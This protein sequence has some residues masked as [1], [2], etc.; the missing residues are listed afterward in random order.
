[1]IKTSDHSFTLE[2]SDS[3]MQ[4]GGAIGCKRLFLDFE[5]TSGERF[6]KGLY[7]YRGHRAAGFAVTWDNHPE[8]YYVPMRH[9]VK[10]SNLSLEHAQAYLKDALT[11]CQVWSNA[12]VKFDAH[13]ALHEGAEFAC[14]LLDTQTGA[15]LIDSDRMLRGGYGLDVLSRDF[16]GRVI[17]DKEDSIQKYLALWNRGNKKAEDYGLVPAD[18]M[19]DYACE[20]VLA[21][22][23]V[24]AYIAKNMPE[25]SRDIWETEQL[26]TPV[27][28]DIERRGMRINPEK[29]EI[30]QLQLMT[31]L[32]YIEEQIH[33]ET[34]L[35]IEPHNS[36]DCY[37]LLC[38]HYGLPVLEFTDK[39]NPS[40]DY[41][42]ML[43][44]GVHPGVVVHPN[45]LRVIKLM[46]RYRDRYTLLHTFVMPYLELHVD[47]ILHPNYNQV[48]RT[49]R[50]SCKEPNAQQLSHEGR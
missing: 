14:R 6:T 45:R 9:F 24:D 13:V 48:V 16:C 7:P 20:D 44:Y 21:N 47:G 3:L 11:K 40:F 27:L 22:R 33:T 34:G 25:M 30:L 1:M 19:G 50:M 46:E 10:E 37:D 38:G 26:L 42:A 41:E 12:N 2:P 35:A 17:K 36:G 39:G 43:K 23:E 8:A 18:K 49:G 32:A 5:T 31:E 29:A 28:F 4:I 15:K